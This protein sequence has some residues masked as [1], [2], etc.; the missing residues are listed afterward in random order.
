MLHLEN[1]TRF[2]SSVLVRP[3]GETERYDKIF[4]TPF[5]ET[6]PYVDKVPF[7]RNWFRDNF[8]AA[9]L[10]N[11]EV[12]ETPKRFSVQGEGF[13]KNSVEFINIATPI[14]FEDTVPFVVRRLVFEN[15]E[16]RA[17]F[18][19]NL[20]ND[21]W[22]GNNNSARLQHIREARMR[23]VEN[24]TPMIRAAN[25]GLS[26]LIDSKGRVRK[27]AEY[28]GEA[29]LMK[30]AIMHARVFEGVKLP[31]SRFIGDWVA[32][33]SL[34]GGILL[35]IGSWKKRSNENDKTSN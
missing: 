10:F 5:G 14:C 22:F 8:G 1:S 25:T 31:L 24:M 35:V 26:C 6:I 21:G 4:L 28:E 11:L 13:A 9:M 17:G 33:L 12:G 7:L 19:I 3:N 32:W 23:C 16:R 18:L 34:I 29:A 2:N 30:S 27:I 20:S 15:G